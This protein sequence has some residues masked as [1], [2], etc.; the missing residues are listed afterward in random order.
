MNQPNLQSVDWT[1]ISA[2]ED[3]GAAA[4]LTRGTDAGCHASRDGWRR[5]GAWAP[6]WLERALLLSDDGAAGSAPAGRMGPE[7]PGH[8]AARR[9]PAPSAISHATCRLRRLVALRHLRRK[10]RLIS[11]KRR[12]ACICRFRCYRMPISPW[13][14]RSRLPT[15][16]VEGIVPDQAADAHSPPCM[17]IVSRRC[18][19]RSSRRTGMPV[20]YW[21]ICGRSDVALCPAEIR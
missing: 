17:T 3:D 7:S 14:G 9:N 5:R 10:R 21:P 19:T 6:E 18:S 2:P 15:L 13:P 12:S 16:Q 8:A 20:M 1:A 11:A 4:H